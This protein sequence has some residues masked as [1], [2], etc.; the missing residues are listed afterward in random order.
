M[1]PLPRCRSQRCTPKRHGEWLIVLILAPWHHDSG[2]RAHGLACTHASV[3]A[4][5]RVWQP[6][7][8]GRRLTSVF[9]SRLCL[10]C[11]HVCVRK[12]LCVLVLR[13]MMADDGDRFTLAGF[14][15]FFCGRAGAYKW[16]T[17][18]PSAWAKWHL[19]EVKPSWR[20]SITV[21]QS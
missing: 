7:D 4:C 2:A 6:S 13:V 20:F 15:V 21:Y 14:F 9:F 12:S 5:V 19:S 18:R 11:K 17:G 3:L 8:G 16:E 1:L 10:E